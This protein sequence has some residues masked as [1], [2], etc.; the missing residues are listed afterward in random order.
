LQP[1]AGH[2]AALLDS[3]PREAADAPAVTT[4]HVPRDASSPI[5]RPPALR[6]RIHQDLALRIEQH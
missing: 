1:D 4:D 3:H 2:V 5:G 6:E